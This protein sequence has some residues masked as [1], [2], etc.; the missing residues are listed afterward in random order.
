MTL[1]RTGPDRTG[2][3][4]IGFDRLIRLRWLD[5]AALMAAEL[6]DGDALHRAMLEQLAGEL[7]GIEGRRKTANVLTRIWWRTP[8]GDMTLRDEALAQIAVC[9]PGER[10]MFHWGMCLLAY[11]V[12]RD[13]AA[14]VGR[15]LR[16]QGS[17]R[18]AQVITRVSAEWG[19]RST[20]QTAVPRIVRSYVDWGVLVATEEKG[21]YRAGTQISLGRSRTAP[22][23]LTGLAAAR[24]GAVSVD[25][26]LDAPEAFA[27]DISSSAGSL[28]SSRTRRF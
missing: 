7:P 15:L 6:R 17:F 27:F 5:R 3:D 24:A 2:P 28:V 9:A 11:P 8:Y 21:I 19:N 18:Q 25:E 13:V 16:L 12:F 4:R 23:L 20:L 26:I 1:D 22:W 14:T 10:L